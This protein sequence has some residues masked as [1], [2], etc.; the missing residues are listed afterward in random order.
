[1]FLLF[2]LVIIQEH[3]DYDPAV[4]HAFVHDI[5]DD[6]SMFPFPHESLDVIIVVFVLSSIHPERY[7]VRVFFIYFFL[8]STGIFAD[9]VS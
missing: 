4:C 1:M 9:A 5:C 6:V 8:P 2:F 3:P 7:G